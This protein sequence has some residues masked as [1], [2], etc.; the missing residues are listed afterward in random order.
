MVI[1]PHEIHVGH[2]ATIKSLFG[3]DCTFYSSQSATPDARVLVIDNI[4]MLSALYRYGEIACI[5]GGYNKSGIHNVLEPAVF[6]LPVIMG[7]EY[8][9]FTEAVAMVKKGF[10]FEAK[11]A[12]AYKDILLH[13]IRDEQGLAALQGY[14]R[15]YIQEH[16]GATAK[17]ISLIPPL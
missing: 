12:T 13:L 11:D 7:P 1:A 2:L 4:G 5:G 3:N 6:G 14:T 17:I 10:A 9:K 8:Q 15:T 16:T